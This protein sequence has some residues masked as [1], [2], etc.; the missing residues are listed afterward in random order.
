MKMSKMTETL[1]F[2]PVTLDVTIQVIYR[3]PNSFVRLSYSNK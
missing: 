1:M 3:G 2:R